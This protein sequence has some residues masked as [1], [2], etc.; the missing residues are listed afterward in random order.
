[1]SFNP[2]VHMFQIPEENTRAKSAELAENLM[3]L[4][5]EISACVPK[6][7]EIFT[8]PESKTRQDLYYEI[9]A[10]CTAQEQGGEI[11]EKT[12]NQIAADMTIFLGEHPFNKRIVFYYPAHLMPDCG[13]EQRQKNP[14]RETFAKTYAEK[15]KEL[16]MGESA[17][18]SM[19]ALEQISALLEKNIVTPNEVEE[20]IR[21][22]AVARNAMC[23]PECVTSK[24]FDRQTFP[25]NE[26]KNAVESAASRFEAQQYLQILPTLMEYGIADA[27]S[28]EKAIHNE[29]THIR[30]EAALIV[31]R[32]IEKGKIRFSTEEWRDLARNSSLSV[33]EAAFS[34][35]SDLLR[36]GAITK[37][38]LPIE[39]IRKAAAGKDT[40]LQEHIIDSFPELME[41]GMI[42]IGQWKNLLKNPKKEI[43]EK[44]ISILP[45]L[46]G[47]NL[48][49]KENFQTPEWIALLTDNEEDVRR[50]AAK[51]IGALLD[52][53][54]IENTDTYRQLLQSTDKATR[55][56]AIEILSA[57]IRKGRITPKEITELTMQIPNLTLPRGFTENPDLKE[58]VMD[59]KML[60]K[61]IQKI[62]QKH[63][64]MLP[65]FLL[66]G[67]AAKGY[68][69]PSSDLDIAIII[70]KDISFE[71]QEEIQNAII[72]AGL[73][74]NV[75]IDGYHTI[76]V[77]DFEQPRL[78]SML[79]EE[80]IATLMIGEVVGSDAMVKVRDAII[81]DFQEK[82]TE[83]E[84]T[85]VLRT[86]ET[87]L[88]RW[89]IAEEAMQRAYTREKPY[90]KKDPQ[91][92][93]VATLAFL[94]KLVL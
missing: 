37:E 73:E 34:I 18:E 71:E 45:E 8:S 10:A 76:P 82:T 38:T 3:E 62:A 85:N 41:M 75:I 86:M 19:E 48:L 63:P 77:S 9:S 60:R 84:E 56:G 21:N 23:V 27:D 12:L 90:D 30:T 79:P 59:V 14:E 53:G 26:W 1:M 57:Q 64:K 88:L 11:P 46:T 32:M 25:L 55:S 49:T 7:V 13:K 78:A 2:E 74:M 67:S 35:L 40:A 47:K 22:P 52:A 89:N 68:S 80:E 15:W 66:L 44:A 83:K 54:I 70:Q 87:H 69:V 94:T 51:M 50:K 31:P 16:V 17:E 39:E 24:I 28:W 33:R 36:L 81:K 6:N 20:I 58:V 43:R 29:K 91:Y 61:A 93:E 42:S 65:G 72:Q 4:S 92:K 5:A